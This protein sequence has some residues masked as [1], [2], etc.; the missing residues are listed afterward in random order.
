MAKA[1]KTTKATE[2]KKFFTTVDAVVVF[3]SEKDLK[4]YFNFAKTNSYVSSF[5]K[6]TSLIGIANEPLLHVNGRGEFVPDERCPEVPQDDFETAV[7]DRGV[8]VAT[9]VDGEMKIYPSIYTAFNGICARAGITGSLIR[10]TELNRSFEPM[11]AETRGNWLTYGFHHNRGGAKFRI[12]DGFID[13]CNSDGYVWLSEEKGYNAVLKELQKEHPEATFKGGSVSHEY[14]YVEIDMNDEIALD[15]FKQMLEGFGVTV[16]SI[17][18]GVY[19]ATSDVGN[20]CMSAF[21]YYELNGTRFRVGKGISLRHEGDASIA[22]FKSKLKNLAMLWQEAEDIVEKLGNTEIKFPAGCLQQVIEENPWL[23]AKA[24]KAVLEE[25]LRKYGN[26]AKSA[27]AFDVYLM[28]ADIIEVQSTLKALTPT[29]RVNFADDVA[30]LLNYDYVKH[31]VP[32]VE[33]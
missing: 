5:C 33:E 1:T 13:A 25:A 20:A 22:V 21:P 17:R 12:C 9:P 2:T 16:E 11:D 6:E 26:G 30:K 18:C 32:Y 7:V 15:G 8:F 3:E 23:P 27:T 19:Y 24:S 10:N 31:D 29:Q 4:N 28:V 14:L